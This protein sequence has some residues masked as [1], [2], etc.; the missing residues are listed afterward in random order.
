MVKVRMDEA[1][2]G[3][4]ELVD[5]EDI[6]AEVAL[7]DVPQYLEDHEYEVVE[8]PI[9]PLDDISMQGVAIPHE[10]QQ[11]SLLHILVLHDMADPTIPMEETVL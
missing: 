2:V 8:D 4:V 11:Q 3:A 5:D 9:Q 6:V 7:V 10:M 1:V